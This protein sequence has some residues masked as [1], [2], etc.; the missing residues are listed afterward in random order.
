VIRDAVNDDIAAIVEIYNEVVAHT[1][2]VWSDTLVTT[3]DR[4]AW[5]AE[6]HARGFPVLVVEQD[7]R[8]VGF[9]SF[10]DFRPWPGYRHTVELSIYVAAECRGRGIG[11]QLLVELVVRARQLGKRTMIAGIEASNVAS[12]A[13]HERL[14]FRCG[15]RLPGVG[16]KFDRSL[17]LVLLYLPLETGDSGSAATLARRMPYA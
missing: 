9:A 4:H 5:L 16:E 17:D 8:V 3:E 15:G 13:L 6:R 10:G 7:G 14:G 11:R 2:A 12:L 1:M